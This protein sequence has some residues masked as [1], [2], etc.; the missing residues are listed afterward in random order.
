MKEPSIIIPLSEYQELE[1]LKLEFV[2]AF[3]K[4]KTIVFHDSY[5]SGHS[6]YPTHK[7]T[8]VTDNEFIF[9][10]QEKIITLECEINKLNKRAINK[11]VIN[12]WWK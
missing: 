5:F 11:P 3:E 1:R 2:T 9:Q 6:G 8:V 4:G 10:L 12:K 7:Y